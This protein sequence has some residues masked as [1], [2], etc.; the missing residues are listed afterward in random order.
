[1]S[2][3]Y[4][5]YAPSILTETQARNLKVC[6]QTLSVE[7]PRKCFGSQCAAWV[8]ELWPSQ[9]GNAPDD[10]VGRGGL[11]GYGTVYRFLGK[12]RFVGLKRVSWTSK[13]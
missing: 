13:E 4:P 8:L 12:A 6:P 10:P 2:N 1:M 7:E 11:A 9:F 3:E 5:L